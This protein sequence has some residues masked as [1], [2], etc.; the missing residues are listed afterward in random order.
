MFSR[1]YKYIGILV[2][3]LVLLG[4]HSFQ[5]NAMETPHHH[6]EESS[7]VGHDCHHEM[8]MDICEKIQNDEMQTSSEFFLFPEISNFIA[9]E[10][11]EKFVPFMVQQKLQKWFLKVF[12][13]LNMLIVIRLWKCS[14][15]LLN[16]KIQ[17]NL[18]LWVLI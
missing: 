7:C 1:V 6:V 13:C 12:Q 18:M 15:L 3:T 5:A 2:I 10:I 9:V 11:K 14:G 16:Q 8:S 4:H 17:N